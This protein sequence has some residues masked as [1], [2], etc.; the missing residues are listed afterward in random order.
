M[1]DGSYYYAN[2]NGSTYYNSGSGNAGSST[3]T[4]PNGN[5]YKK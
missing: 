5:V 3:Y 1:A 2:G 4:A